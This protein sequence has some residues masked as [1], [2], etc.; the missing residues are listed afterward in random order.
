MQQQGFTMLGKQKFESDSL[1]ANTLANAR[2]CVLMLRQPVRL[3]I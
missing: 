2:L 3:P 1:A